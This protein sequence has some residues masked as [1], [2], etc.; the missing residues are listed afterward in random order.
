MN[1]GQQGRTTSVCTVQTLDGL[2]LVGTLDVPGG[3]ARCAA[4]LIH[5]AGV[6]R[7]EG[8]FFTRLAAGLATVG[9]TSLRIDLPGHGDSEGR[10]E[11]LSLSAVLNVIQSGI[12]YIHRLSGFSSVSLVAASFSGGMAAYFAAERSAIVDRLVLVNPL[13][14]YKARFVDEKSSWV[15]GY[16]NEKAGRQLLAQGYVGHSP[17]FKLGRPLLNEVFWLEPRAAL[18][19]VVAPTLIVH[20]TEDTFIPV[21]SS[22]TADRQLTCRHR[23]IELVGAQH[24]VAVHDDPTY[25]DPQ[26]QKWQ[27][28]VIGE[29][30]QW[31]SEEQ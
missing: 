20:G 7:E 29:I 11:D 4:L 21:E 10:Q 6:T 1:D 30:S 5:G 19:R 18:P 26:T 3:P 15:D 27:E 22:R 16:I 9:V 28:S 2:Q 31:I 24:G 17:T 14:D 13:I 23:L 25:A 8:G 12:D